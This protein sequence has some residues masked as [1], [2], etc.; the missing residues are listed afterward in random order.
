MMLKFF[1]KSILRNTAL[2][3]FFDQKQKILKE[4]KRIFDF[5]SYESNK[6]V[7]LKNILKI[8]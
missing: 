4:K 2:R 7:L 8:N 6:N 3:C 5:R 1:P